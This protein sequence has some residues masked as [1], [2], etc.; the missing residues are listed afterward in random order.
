MSYD[1]ISLQIMWSRLLQIADECWTTIWRTSFST[2]IGEALDFGCE[3]LDANG[4]TLA[5]SPRSMPVFN[6]TLPMAVKH[7]MEKIP[8]DEWQDSDVL[9]HN[10]PWYCA[11]HLNDLAVVRP[12][13]FK[14]KLVAMFG[15][16]GHV[17]DIGGTANRLHTRELYD[18]GLQIPPMKLVKAG[19]LNEELIEIIRLNVRKSEM[20]VGDIQALL[21]A[22]EVAADRVCAFLAEY[23]MEDFAS[24]AAVLQDLAERAMRQAVQEIPDGVYRYEIWTDGYKEPLRIPAEVRVEGDELTVDYSGAPPQVD[25]GSINCTFS[26]AAAHSVYALKCLLSPQIPSNAGCYRP[27]RIVAPPGSI[28]NCD[29][30]A[31]V[32]SRTKTGWHLGPLI[33]GALA[34]AIPDRVR[35]FTSF[36]T[37]VVAM[38]K[39]HRGQPFHDH[40]MQG[41]GQ[42]GARNSDGMPSLLFPTSA[43]NVSTEMFETRV[44]L[45]VEAKE[46]LPD[47]GGPGQFRGG[48]GQ[49]IRVR[50]RHDATQVRIS[51]RPEGVFTSTP[52]F[53]GGQPGGRV[54]LY[55]EE[56]EGWR[57]LGHGGLFP[58]EQTRQV[59]RLE[60]GGGSG[61]GDPS[62]R[63][64]DAIRRDVRSG[65]V[66]EAGAAN[67]YGQKPDRK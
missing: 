47:T 29:K 37:G 52:G 15:G 27:L 41:G 26:Y 5:H 21:S 24:L 30:P 25:Q 19:A 10:D 40:M 57:D 66:T 61:F 35:A 31:P 38:G 20:V 23:G 17:S 8:L 6:L 14:G 59:I 32:N 67:D 28:V 53:E 36:P 64:P 42:G 51:V 48:V 2:I 39:D 60:L 62:R 11:G 49:V 34:G 43:G 3:L 13:F 7:M 45:L 56:E 12:I 50:K 54:R 4:E 1:P 44:P 9:I 18:E 55:M 65:L 46:Y 33:Y 63:D 16:I 22:A 58:L